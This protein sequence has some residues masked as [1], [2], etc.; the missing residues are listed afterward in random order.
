[1][2]ARLP[3]NYQST[4]STFSRWHGMYLVKLAILHPLPIW[5]TVPSLLAIPTASQVRRR[6]PLPG[7]SGGR[8][9]STLCSWG[10][11]QT[12]LP[13]RMFLLII[14]SVFYYFF[15]KKEMKMLYRI[16][17]LT[18]LWLVFSFLHLARGFQIFPTGQL[19]SSK[20]RLNKPLCLGGG[21]RLRKPWLTLVLC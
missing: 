1:M 7:R 8:G 16:M 12:V 10:A 18:Y 4:E 11:R 21:A 13:Q 9:S 17:K 6:G 15:Y 19:G 20:V 14:P 5:V 2:P 3:I